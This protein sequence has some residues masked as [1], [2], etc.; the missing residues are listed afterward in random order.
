MRMVLYH[1]FTGL[2]FTC[3]HCGVLQKRRKLF[4]CMSSGPNHIDRK[5]QHY[6]CMIDILVRCGELK[7]AVELNMLVKPN[8][9]VWLALLSACRLH[10]D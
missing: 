6:T 3:S 2:L 7:E 4:D 5:I 8:E 9:M 1:V 10:S